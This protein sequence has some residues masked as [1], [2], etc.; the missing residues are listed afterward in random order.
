MGV[1]AT[2]GFIAIVLALIVG[3]LL[4]ETSRGPSFRAADHSSME[5]C[6]AAIPREW[7]QGSMER[8]GAEA[9]CYYV[10][11]RGQGAPR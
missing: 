4:L 7:R 9:A 11:V 6:V 8:D 1:K 10:H 2:A 3:A 5:E